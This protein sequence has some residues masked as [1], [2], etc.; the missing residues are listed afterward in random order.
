MKV[1]IYARYSTDLQD[2]TSIAGQI[3]NCEAL[4]AREG[5]DVVSRYQDAARSGN[6]DNRPQYQQLFT[7]SEAGLFDAII[8]DETSRLT[9]R[10]GEIPRLLEILSFRNQFLVD[11]SGFDSRQETASLLASIYGGIDSLELR[12]IKRRTHRGLRERHTAGFS[13]GGR[14]YGYTSEA[15]DPTD[16][17]TKWRK[18]VN[19]DQA[20][21]VVWIFERYA[22]GMGGKRIAA[23]LN[24]L[25]V[26]SPGASWKRVQRRKDGMW[27]HSAILGMAKR[28]SGIL[29]NEIY[30]GNV[31]W[32]RSEWV[33][34]PG[35]G[36]RTYRLRPRD[37]W[38]IEEHPELR[39]VPQELW[40]RVQ[41]RLSH[42]HPGLPKRGRRG[43]YLLTG[44]L[45]CYHCGGSLTMIDQRCYGCGTRN[46][47]GDAACDNAIRIRRDKLEDR[48]LSGVREQLL[49]PDTIR[50]AEKEISK[51]LI[52]PDQDT[53]SIRA[54]IN[55]TEAEIARVVEAITKVGI[56][57]A[58]ERKLKDLEQRQ[59]GLRREL[60]SAE[61]IVEL[62]D[63][64][65]ISD[66]W[67]ATVERLGDLP[68]TLT[69]GELDTARNALK[70]L[71]G[72]VRVDRHGKGYAELGLPTNMVAGAG[73]EPATFGL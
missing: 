18:I 3:T 73:F 55:V 48:F 27:Q 52:A 72:E 26:P 15:V 16:P 43:T 59:S 17:D 41:A 22:E 33:K 46:R 6:D 67:T 24:R 69:P 10:P 70:G 66:H 4:A 62:P 8:V 56:S 14:T 54:E 30:I 58:L 50:W 12:K 5:F 37:Q 47:G 32:N 35:T 29:R 25:Q 38:I 45:K 61:K 7:D 49:S 9:R 28:G 53:G 42:T 20:Q 19:Q 40:D 1:A 2:K 34:R 21:W 65:V 39:I 44:I 31:I 68:K 60:A 36:T 11:C 64:S 13:A 51:L 23:E 57:D 71:F 63:I